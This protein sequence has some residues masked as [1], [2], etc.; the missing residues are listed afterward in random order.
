MMSLISE[1]NALMQ[2]IVLSIPDKRGEM[3]SHS[4]LEMLT[5]L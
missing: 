1:V 4:K 5:E 3:Y 2:Q